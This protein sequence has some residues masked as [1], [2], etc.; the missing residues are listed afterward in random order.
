MDE[1]C[2]G[3]ARE[4]EAL[5]ARAEQR[6]VLIV[7]LV[8]NAAMFV[9]E[10]TAGLVARSAA[11]QADSVDM[12]G[13]ALVYALSLFAVHRGARWQAG[14]AFA[15]GLVILGFFVF[16]VVE[17][18]LKLAYGVTPSSGL[19]LVFGTLALAAN[20][21]CLRLL[22]PFRALN[23]NMR[24]T[25]ECSRND[26]IANMGVLVAA[27]GVALAGSGWPDIIVGG[28]IA[29]LFL[30]SALSALRE[31]WPQVRRATS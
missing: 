5:A 18:S 25:F 4:V 15:K 11:L 9:V 30:R 23:I 16:V 8:I 3:K 26:V 22:W 28:V 21:I 20:L 29:A 14:A 6:R 1:C 10:F 17:I 7:V 2:A 13:D 24:S 19:M 27:A 12:L 31:A